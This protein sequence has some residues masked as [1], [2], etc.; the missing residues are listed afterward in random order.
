MPQLRSPRAGADEAAWAAV[1][2]V[3]AGQEAGSGPMEYTQGSSSGTQTL[4]VCLHLAA[5][6]GRL[7]FMSQA[8]STHRRRGWPGRR[9][10]LLAW[11]LHRWRRLQGR[12]EQDCLNW[13]GAAAHAASAPAVQPGWEEVGSSH[14][15]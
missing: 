13:L 2:A 7:P 14:A 3:G 8:S 6:G 4:S 1:A 9:R 12:P 15:K 5:Q 10:A 11:P